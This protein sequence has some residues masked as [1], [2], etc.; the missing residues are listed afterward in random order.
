MRRAFAGVIV[1]AAAAAIVRAQS[2]TVVVFETEKGSIE[3]EVDS[4][5]APASAANMTKIGP[6]RGPPIS[7]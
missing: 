1:L 4:V 3:L 7:A 2:N 5:H 6:L